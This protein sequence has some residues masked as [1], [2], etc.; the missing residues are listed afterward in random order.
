M[1]ALPPKADIGRVHWDVRFEPKADMRGRPRHLGFTRKAI[2]FG[3]VRCEVR[4]DTAVQLTCD[5]CRNKQD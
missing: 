3:T 1:S 2:F 4:S 5:S